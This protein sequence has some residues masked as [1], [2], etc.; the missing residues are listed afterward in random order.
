VGSIGPEQTIKERAKANSGHRTDLPQKSAEGYK[1][2]G[3]TREEIAKLA[4]SECN[5]IDECKEWS[6]KAQA[7]ASYA[8]QAD[9]H[10]MEKAAMRIRARAVRRCGELLK[11]IEKAQPGP[12][13]FKGGGPPQLSPR[14]EAA[15]EAGLSPDQAKTAIRVANVPNEIFVEQVDSAEPPTITKLA[16]LSGSSRKNIERAKPIVQSGCPLAPAPMEQPR[17]LTGRKCRRWRAFGDARRGGG[18]LLESRVN[19]QQ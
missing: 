7:L 2:V 4:L 8:R 10:E 12:K 3:E 11:E 19:P 13:E 16:E 1:P 18:G 15:K 9:D 5:R 17:E 6:D 14:K